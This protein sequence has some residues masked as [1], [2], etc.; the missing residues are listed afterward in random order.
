[1]TKFCIDCAH[2]QASKRPA[3]RYHRC[4]AVTPHKPRNLV[5]GQRPHAYAELERQ[6]FDSRDCGPDA[7]FFQSRPVSALSFAPFMRA[8]RLWLLLAVLAA[9]AAGVVVARFL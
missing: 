2:F 6:G 5:T 4:A 8:C 9:A 1:M 3:A 7:K